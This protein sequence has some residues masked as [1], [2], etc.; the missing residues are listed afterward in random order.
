MFIIA[1]VFAVIIDKME[2]KN[3]LRTTEV[4]IVQNSVRTTSLGQNLLVPI[5]KK[6]RV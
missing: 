5:K 3:S 1:I 2:N 4:Q 6:K